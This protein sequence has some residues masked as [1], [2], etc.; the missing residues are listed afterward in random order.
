M[1]ISHIHIGLWYRIS[2]VYTQLNVETVLFQTILLTMSTVSISKT[3]QFQTIQNSTISKQYYFKTVLFQAIRFSISI[4]FSFLQLIGRSLSS[5]TTPGQS[6]PES[7]GNEG[8]FRIPQSFS[9]TGASLSDCLVSYLG[10]SLEEYYPS[11]EKQCMYF[12]ATVD[13]ATNYWITEF[14]QLF[15]ETTLLFLLKRQRK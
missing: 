2:F 15:S 1:S 14:F 4:H 6:G 13:W 11:A 3:V 5:A 8:V 10:F 7:D 9:I 12:A